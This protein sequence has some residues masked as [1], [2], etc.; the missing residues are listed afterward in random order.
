M[1]IGGPSVCARA[2]ATNDIQK[3]SVNDII[4]GVQG[5]EPPEALA[6]LSNLRVKSWNFIPFSLQTDCSKEYQL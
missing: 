2:P 5:A 6:I 4:L 1:D 3:I